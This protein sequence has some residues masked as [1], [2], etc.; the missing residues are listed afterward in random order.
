MIRRAAFVIAVFVAA[1]GIHPVAQPAARAAALSPRIDAILARPEFRHSTFGIE[2]YSLDAN[3]PVYTLNAEKLFVP[4]STTK[5]I[6]M[7]SA[8]Q[9]LGADYRF[10]TRVYRTGD[11]DRDGT[12]HGDLVL[13][14][15][16]DTNLS[17]R[18][19]AGDTL[20]FENVDH[21][22]GGPDSRGLDGDP[23]RVVRELAAAVATR[24]VKRIEG[25]VIVDASLFPEGQREGGTRFVISPIV[26]NDNAIDVVIAPGATV[27]VPAQLT[28]SP[29][30]AYA[31]FINNTKTAPA[32]ARD[33]LR[34]TSDVT[35]GDG[36]HTVTFGGSVAADSRPTLSGYR[37]PQPSRFAEIV[38]TEALHE[39][40]I[41]AAARLVEA[42]PNVATLLPS[43]TAERVVAEHVSPPFAEEVK[44]TLKVSHNLHASA[45]PFLLGALVGHKGDAETG[46][47]E[48]RKFLETTGA[49]VTGASQSDGAGADAHFTPDFMVHY[50][51]FMSRQPAARVFHDALPILGT[52]GT[53]W[54]IQ[55]KSAAVGHVYA[56]TGT[57]SAGDLLHK[58]VMVTGKGLAG[59]MTTTDGRHLAFAIFANNVPVKDGASVTPLVGD[60]LGEIAAAA[61]DAPVSKSGSLNP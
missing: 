17:G 57:Y 22:Y 35:H 3:R 47:D 27:D 20:A 25:H 50:L 8:L 11:I 9:L 4:G 31:R 41:A 40:G 59:Y 44:I 15:S 46:F 13:V 1:S 34:I 56:K 52:D 36:T 30:T 32:G 23:L 21:T 33:D 19:R 55:T 29:V 45:T 26:V 10:H 61:Y 58:A 49:D 6:T 7:G 18:I 5:L 60:A 42:P 16:G 12:L 2:F 39:R 24:G 48:I 53:L 38:F 43:Y 37:V 54:N 28:V 14:A 51:A